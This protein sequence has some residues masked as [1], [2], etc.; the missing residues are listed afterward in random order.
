MSCELFPPRNLS[1]FAGIWVLYST[2]QSEAIGM[3]DDCS[4]EEHSDVSDMANADRMVIFQRGEE[5]L[6]IWMGYVKLR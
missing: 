2:V 4:R 6:Y 1:L 5:R 3:D